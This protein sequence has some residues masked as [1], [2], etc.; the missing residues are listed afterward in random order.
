MSDN[1][2]WLLVFFRPIIRCLIYI[3]HIIEARKVLSFF[4]FAIYFIELRHLFVLAK[5]NKLRSGSR[6]TCGYLC[7]QFEEW[8][9]VAT[10]LGLMWA[11]SSVS[12][13]V[14]C[15]IVAALKLVLPVS[16][17]WL[18]M[19]Y[20]F[21]I[22][23]LF[24]HNSCWWYFKANVGAFLTWLLFWKRKTFN[25]RANRSIAA[26]LFWVQITRPRSIK[27]ISMMWGSLH[28]SWGLLLEVYLQK[29]IFQTG[30]GFYK[31]QFWLFKYFKWFWGLYFLSFF[32]HVVSRGQF[33]F[34]QIRDYCLEFFCCQACEASVVLMTYALDFLRFVC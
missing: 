1:F 17:F 19:V 31:F 24:Q 23:S 13:N 12:Y 3:L 33:A 22:C 27:W 8:A 9:L 5:L 34:G 29:G 6:I 25:I 28:D 26:W 11:L 15:T 18:Q 4:I 32:W 7:M 20:F 30:Y 16:T 14:R 21:H 2:I 10:L